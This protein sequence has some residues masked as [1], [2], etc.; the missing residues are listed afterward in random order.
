MNDTMI[1]EEQTMIRKQWVCLLLA[2]LMLCPLF[3]ASAED[4]STEGAWL[5]LYCGSANIGDSCSYCGVIRDVWICSSCGTRNL[6]DS[7]RSCG[8]GRE[9]SLRARAFGEEPL[10]AYP[11]LSFLAARGEPDAMCAQAAYY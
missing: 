1:R 10:R 9:D 6:F 4:A 11:A 3:P 7:C 8:L 5:C 2:V